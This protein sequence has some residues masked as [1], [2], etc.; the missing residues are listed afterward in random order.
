MIKFYKH[1][2]ID[3]ESWNRCITTS[4]SS[5][6]FADYDFLTLA[7]P[8][9]NALVEDD[10]QSVM[11]LPW[12]KKHGINYIYNPFFYSRLGIFSQKTCTPQLVRDF[13]CAIPKQYALVQI[14]LN[15]SNPE[16]LISGKWYHQISHR[17]SLNDSYSSIY[18]NFAS[19]HKRNIKSA[20]GHFPSLDTDIC[21]SDIIDLFRKNR[22]K[23][24]NIKIK[25]VDYGFFLRMSEYA[26]QHELL[27]LWGARDEDGRL[28]AGAVFLRDGNRI[29]FWFS[30]RD[31]TQAHKKAMF[32]LMDEYIL[33]H[34]QQPLSL[35][36]NGSRNENVARFYAGFGGQKYTFPALAFCN[37]PLMKPIFKLTG[38]L[39]N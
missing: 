36:F 2:E 4:S 14:N 33:Q 5:T 32:F 20:R 18:Q 6:I 27:D 7:N 30:G 21:L 8:Q 34:A 19:N 26:Q 15:E 22:G 24:R 35:D 13:V 16:E 28:L 17:L 25:D 31:E 37:S 10:Y 11:P 38:K 1:S 23:D 12:R 29:W 39:K 9:W 3:K